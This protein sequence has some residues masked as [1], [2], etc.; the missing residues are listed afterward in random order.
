[1]FFWQ[2]LSHFTAYDIE[3]VRRKPMRYRGIHIIFI[4]LTASTLFLSYFPALAQS[5]TA[6]DPWAPFQFLVGNWSGT[7]SGKPGE[8]AAGSCSFSFDLGRKVLIRR[9]KAEFSPQPGEKLGTTHEDLM[10][11]YQQPGDSQ[12]R[13]IYFDNEGHIINY[14]LTFP[15]KQPSV[16]FESEGTDKTPR[17]RLVHELEADGL[18]STE[19]A[20]APPGGSF[21]TYTKGTV[22]RSL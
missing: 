17:F 4:L 1:M 13:A 18:L 22:K 2:I 16:A 11:I 12:F 8:A 19:F 9:N 6:K 21:K 15:A 5:S 14:T 20:I 3:I 7:G 10:I